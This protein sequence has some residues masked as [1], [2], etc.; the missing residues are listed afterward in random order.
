MF[1]RPVYSP[2][3]PSYTG[4]LGP[5]QQKAAMKV[6]KAADK[7]AK[8]LMKYSMPP[9]AQ[10]G[11]TPYDAV[12]DFVGAEGGLLTPEER[13]QR[14]KD[15]W[16]RKKEKMTPEE[17]ELF[18][19]ARR[20][21]AK[22]LS[23]QHKINL[24]RGFKLWREGLTPDQR[25][26][27]AE[28]RRTK[29]KAS[30]TPER[31][32]KLQE[33]RM[34]FQA[35]SKEEKRAYKAAKRSKQFGRI[36]PEATG[37]L[38]AR[39]LIEARGGAVGL[40]SLAS[41][42]V[43]VI[44]KGISA[45]TKMGMRRIKKKNVAA[46]ELEGIWMRR[47]KGKSPRNAPQFWRRVY[48]LAHKQIPLYFEDRNLANEMAQKYINEHAKAFMGK[49]YSKILKEKNNVEKRPAT[50]ADFFEPIIQSIAE[51][52]GAPQEAESM[53][54]A[55][56]LQ[57]KPSGQGLAEDLVNIAKSPEARKIMK[58]VGRTVWPKLVSKVK[59]FVRGKL[60]KTKRGSKVLPY[61]EKA[62]DV[63]SSTVTDMLSDKPVPASTAPAIQ[64]GDLPSPD[65]LPNIPTAGSMR[66]RGE[67]KDRWAGKVMRDAK[68]I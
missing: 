54:S 45:L 43:P 57:I 18:H 27:M 20:A 31:L 61:I 17:R 4:V 29:A 60:V 13:S 8:T 32:Q 21:A 9:Q 62:M 58:S 25:A 59:S 26:A 51:E 40:A 28:K 65:P 56:P 68:K 35:L 64:M 49:V 38:S 24:M 55:A 46:G 2:L 11:P 14:M 16:K 63:G 7:Y 36:V 33:G 10:A 50:L 47:A 48:S 52:S 37:L 53:L 6:Q 12:P 66:S 42:A 34:R 22:P 67:S 30:M 3:I 41:M 19:A 23:A 44:I 1:G 39:G 15:A 5:H